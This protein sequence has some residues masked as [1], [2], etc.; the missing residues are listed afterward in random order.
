MTA[1]LVALGLGIRSV[2]LG[3]GSAQCFWQ[4]SCTQRSSTFGL[5]AGRRGDRQTEQQ[6]CETL[7]HECRLMKHRTMWPLLRVL[8]MHRRY[9]AD[10]TLRR[11]RNEGRARPVS[12]VSKIEV[13][14]TH[15][16]LA[17]NIS[18]AT[19]LTLGAATPAFA[20]SPAAPASSKTTAPQGEDPPGADSGD[21]SAPP[22]VEHQGVIVPPP[23]GDLGIH[24]QVPDPNAGTPEEVIPPSSA[25]GEPR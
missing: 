15:E 2:D 3:P 23:T 8:A 17:T 21:Q 22:T 19:A 18:A 7:T 25:K 13:D 20:A 4:V 5:S 9:M 12:S 10:E 14:A 1:W 16:H 11:S 24:T 6:A